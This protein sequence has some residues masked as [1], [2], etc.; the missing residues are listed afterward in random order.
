GGGPIRRV[1][2]VMDSNHPKSP[3]FTR[4]MDTNHPNTP[5]CFLCKAQPK[6]PKGY[7]RH[8]DDHHSSTLLKSGIF[9]KCSCGHRYASMWSHNKHNK[10]CTGRDFTLHKVDEN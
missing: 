5:Q 9:L 2:G 8:L 6:T 7:M 4:V 1:T 10:G 3:Q